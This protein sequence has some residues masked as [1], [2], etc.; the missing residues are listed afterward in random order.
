MYFVGGTYYSFRGILIAVMNGN[1]IVL[2]SWYIICILAFY[3][4]YWLIMT[5]CK[6]HY[7]IMILCGTV[8]YFLYA[9]FCV[10]MGY[11]RYWYNASHLLIVGM[12]WATYERSILEL[13]DKSY[14][15]I[16]PLTWIS[17]VVLCLFRRKAV[18]MVN[19]PYIS[20]ILTFVTAI[21]FVLSVIMFSLKVQIGNKLLDYLGEISLEIYISQGLF[22]TVLRSCWI[23]VSNELLWC[24]L[25][26]VGTIAFSYC[27]HKVFQN[28]L[29]K[30]KRLLHHLRT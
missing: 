8:W 11:D 30:Y 29:N 7:F 4:V 28:V 27:L 17:F 14:H 2:Y 5:V 18:A 9:I 26:L 15:F 6:K 20:F 3:V 21:L 16:A 1:P 25:V 22:M 13:L 19:Y 24:I 12:I 23:Y 10:K